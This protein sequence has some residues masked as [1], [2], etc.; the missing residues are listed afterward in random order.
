[1]VA[2][3]AG[4]N[5]RQRGVIRP[6]RGPVKAG[7]TSPAGEF[8]LVGRLQAR[9]EAARGSPVDEVWI[10]DDAAVVC[11]PSGR[12]LLL[13]TDLVVAGVHVDLAF[14]GLD[15]VGYKS[16]MVA[17]SDMA[18]MGARPD[19]LLVSVAAPAGTDVD[20]LAKGVAEAAEEVRCVVVGGDLSA[21]PVLMVSVAVAGSL[22]GPAQPGPILR[23]G[24][25]PG[26][27]ILVTGP[28]GA[29]AAG[30]RWLRHP[31]GSQVGDQGRIDDGTQ[32]PGAEAIRAHRRPVARLDEGEVARIAGATAA[33]D[34][35]DGLV[36]DI[37]HL[38]TASGVG[39]EL[40][41]VPAAPGSTVEEARSGG[42]EYELL[43]T[44]G[45]RP[46][47]ERAFEA[48]GLRRPVRLGTCTM[49]PDQLSLGGIPLPEGGWTHDLG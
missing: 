23:S 45:D 34:V 47:L 30:L 10:G 37:R 4:L 36:A 7:D 31:T 44:T 17:V 28:L 13:A 29:S 3:T 26:D 39:V 11:P 1:M 16:V 2:A 25:R 8:A 15:D 35:S 27:E 43:L 49:S 41:A 9:F 32:S 14:C 40:D 6:N 46:R 5:G 33:I 18:A 21:S 12:Q 20:L 42:E 38:A 19:Q 24:A 22:H 48:A